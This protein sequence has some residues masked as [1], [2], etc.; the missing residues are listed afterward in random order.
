M[1][2]RERSDAWGAAVADL[3]KGGPDGR[4]ILERDD[5][6]IEPIA[7]GLMLAP[8]SE[9]PRFERS[10]LRFARGRVLD[11][12]C[13]AG[14][15]ALEMQRRGLDVVG[16]DTSPRTL[17]VA[18][19]RGVRDLRRL[20]I[21]NVSR[22]LGLFDTVLLLGNNLGLLEGLA[23]GRRHLRRIA[24]ATTDRARIIATT[25]DPYV[26]NA[27]EHPPY[28][29][30]NRS[31]GRLGGQIR[32]RVRYRS[33]VDPWFDYLFVSRPELDRLLRGTGWEVRRSFGNAKP[34]YAV[35]IEKSDQA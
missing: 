27:P 29:R 34:H 3:Y 33:L 32:M 25:R 35:V 2:S 23:E 14:R 15:H 22:R 11:V 26:T 12:G 5:G 16:I 20:G 21:G 24:A 8:P 10:A 1:S 28:H 31:R 7:L 4:A 18:R 17:T 6:Y 13:G 9:W 30:R 19:A